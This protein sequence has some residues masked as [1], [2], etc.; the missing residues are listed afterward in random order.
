M[1]AAWRQSWRAFGKFDED[2]LTRIVYD[3]EP[4]QLARAGLK[5]WEAG[6]RERICLNITANCLRENMDVDI[7]GQIRV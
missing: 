6:Y 1:Q 2:Q 5:P 7:Y 3:E 4:F